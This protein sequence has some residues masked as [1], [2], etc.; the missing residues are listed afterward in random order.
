[1][2][3]TNH[4]PPPTFTTGAGGGRRGSPGS[5]RMSTNTNDMPAPTEG[6]QRPR[7]AVLSSVLA[8][9]SVPEQASVVYNAAARSGRREARNLPSMS[10]DVDG[11]GVEDE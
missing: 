4:P 3:Q 9:E 1:M 7:Q 10:L 2:L 8:S 6:R 5:L 11:I